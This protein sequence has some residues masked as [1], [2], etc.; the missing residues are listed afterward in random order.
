MKRLGGKPLDFL[1]EPDGSIVEV[2]FSN[3]HGIASG[4]DGN[5]VCPFKWVRIDPR[6][7]NWLI[8]TAKDERNR[9][10]LWLLPAKK[11]RPFLTTAKEDT[12]SYTLDAVRKRWHTV[13]FDEFG[14][15]Y[16]ELHP[17]CLGGSLATPRPS[18]LRTTR[19][20]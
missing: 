20:L 5:Y 18:L 12:I 4:S 8:L 14:L 13:R 1:F 16:E 3:P 9:W 6:N 7:F 10:R 19:N 15:T 17:L 11:V 2:K